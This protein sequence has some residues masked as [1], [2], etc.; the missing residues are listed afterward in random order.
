MSDEIIANLGPLAPLAGVWKSDQGV[1]MSRI[2]GEATTTK[3]RE[4]IVFEPLG[5]VNNGP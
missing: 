4:R 1:D 3:F 5:P 2:H